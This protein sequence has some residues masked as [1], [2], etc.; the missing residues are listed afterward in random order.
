MEWDLLTI[1]HFCT[2]LWFMRKVTFPKHVLATFDCKV[3][4]LIIRKRLTVKT[5]IN[6]WCSS[7]CSIGSLKN[8]LDALLN[9]FNKA[10]EKTRISFDA[11]FSS[12]YVC[13]FLIINNRSDVCVLAT[14][15]D[16]FT[17]VDTP[18][19]HTQ[20]FMMKGNGAIFC[21]IGVW[22][23]CCNTEKLSPFKKLVFCVTKIFTQCRQNQH[24]CAF[25]EFTWPYIV[26]IISD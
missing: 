9:K 14:W 10:S 12:L 19:S 8:N 18:N 17:A 15:C 23:S 24:G 13:C 26:T 20:G 22:Y 4:T 1:R 5:K 3:I 6:W 25:S 7:C 2:W 16:T 11:F 21:V